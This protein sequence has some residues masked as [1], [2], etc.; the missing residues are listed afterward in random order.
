MH[1]NLSSLTKR[2]LLH[3]SHL[4]LASVLLLGGTLLVQ[5]LVIPT[6][7]A[8]HTT[9]LSKVVLGPSGDQQVIIFD[10]SQGRAVISGGLVIGEIKG[11]SGNTIAISALNAIIAGGSF[12]TIDSKGVNSIIGAGQSNSVSG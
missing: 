5:A 9:T 11:A 7:K 6:E 8:T 4:L 3:A 10:H 2:M 12:N 1:S